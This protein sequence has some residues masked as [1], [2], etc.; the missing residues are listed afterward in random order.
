MGG[1]AY[2]GGNNYRA[3]R[4]VSEIRTPS[5]RWVIMEE[6]PESVND[7]WGAFRMDLPPGT[8]LIEYP[9]C[10]HN[11]GAWLTFSDGHVEYHRWADPRTIPRVSKQAIPL[12]VP[13]NPVNADMAWLHE[14]TTELR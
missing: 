6:R 4:N 3:Y 9:G 14:R 5:K 12:Q 10:Y 8:W 11:L 2:C 7:A 13:M 1:D